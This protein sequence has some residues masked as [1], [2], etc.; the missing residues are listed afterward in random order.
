MRCL[1]D[2]RADGRVALCSF[3]PVAG[4]DNPARLQTLSVTVLANY[5]KHGLIDKNSPYTKPQPRAND[6]W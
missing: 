4:M 5:S 2:E 1:D 6:R 3:V